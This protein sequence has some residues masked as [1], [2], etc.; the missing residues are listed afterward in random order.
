MTAKLYDR[1]WLVIGCVG[2]VGIFG[3]PYWPTAI[4]P[5][6][7]GVILA[8]AT[9]SILLFTLVVD[10]PDGES[11]E[12][13]SIS[14]RDESP[15]R[16]HFRVDPGPI[17]VQV[18]YVQGVYGMGEPITLRGASTRLFIRDMI[19]ES[20]PDPIPAYKEVI[21][22]AAELACELN[23][24]LNVVVTKTGDVVLMAPKEE[25]DLDADQVALAGSDAIRLLALGDVA[26]T[27]PN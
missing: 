12:L 27:K 18:A 4:A 13:A 5:I 1:L 19:R 7:S 3:Y 8:F 22:N 6:V 9:L 15:E 21:R 25:V 17:D 20:R 23:G 16:V 10:R 24:R 11:V 26:H 14:E 2:A